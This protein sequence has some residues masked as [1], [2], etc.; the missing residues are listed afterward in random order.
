MINIFETRLYLPH[1][2]SKSQ[3]HTPASFLIQSISKEQESDIVNAALAR[4][5]IEG[6][7]LLTADK[8]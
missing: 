1:I 8:R 2:A 5:I 4:E 6:S 7:I 3:T